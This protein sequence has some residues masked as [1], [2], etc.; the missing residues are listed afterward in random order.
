MQFLDIVRVVEM[1]TR[2][3]FEHVEIGKVRQMPQQHDRYIDLSG[4]G[5]PAFGGQRYRIL[6]FD[7]DVAEVGY[8]T[9]N[10]YAA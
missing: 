5:R 4:F 3:A 6:L 7:F 2:V 10:R 8:D 1:D 9:Q